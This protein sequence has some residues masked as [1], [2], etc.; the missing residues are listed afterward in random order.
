MNTKTAAITQRG[1]IATDA[2]KTTNWK[3][4]YDVFINL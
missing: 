4:I 3:M 1:K 2:T